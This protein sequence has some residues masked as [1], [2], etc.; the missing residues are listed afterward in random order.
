MSTGPRSVSRGARGA[1]FPGRRV[2]MVAPNHCWG[3]WMAAGGAKKSQQCHKYFLQY[4]RPTF[5]S[6]RPQFRTRWRQTCFLP[7]APSN[8]V[9][10]WLVRAPPCADLENF[11]AHWARRV[12]LKLKSAPLPRTAW[13]F[14]I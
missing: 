9:T 1:Q 5:A 11:T 6:E 10:T 2:T 8:L 4:S 13:T 3:R 12:T 7:L 14:Y